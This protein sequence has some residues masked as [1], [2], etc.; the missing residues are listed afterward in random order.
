VPLVKTRVQ[1]IYRN[2]N[3]SV[4]NMNGTTPDYLDI[5]NWQMGS[6]HMFT[7]AD[8]RGSARVC[9]IGT[10]VVRELFQDENPLGKS[11]RLNNV[12]FRV[13]GVLATKGANMTGN[14]QDDVLLCPWTTIKRRVSA[15]SSQN[16][17]ANGA[18]STSSASSTPL[19]QMNTLSQLYP[20]TSVQLYPTE[21]AAQTADTPLPVKF[22]NIDMVLLAAHGA[23]RVPLAM[24]QVRELLRER[25]HLMP[26]Q[27]DDFNVHNL[28][29]F[30]EAMSSMTQ[31]MT[32]LLLYVAAIS[33]V[34]GGV[35]IMNIMLVSVTERTR[36]I[37]LRMA[38]GARARDILTQF[39]IEAII[40]SLIG[41]AA[42]IALGRCA[43]LAVRYFR[44]YPTEI[45]VPAIIISVLVSAVIGIV[46]GF[47]PAWKASRLDPIEA[48]RY[49]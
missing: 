3:W 38:V 22:T 29:E 13:V 36:E 14:D 17:A 5:H 35:G 40:L 18:A 19:N 39:L 7:D 43:S 24:H 26:G 32:T 25:H 15:Q 41:G 31:T 4:G 47:Y 10:T 9:V 37:G 30:A 6:G 42:G 46:F 20:T 23:N 48:L 2:R 28:T 12:S 8:V 44:H 21:S 16:T 11:I 49:E 33:L 1:L 27:P 45:S 34:V